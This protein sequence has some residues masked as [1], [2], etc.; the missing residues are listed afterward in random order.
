MQQV[1]GA[2]LSDALGPRFAYWDEWPMAASLL[3]PG[4]QW[5]PDK[6]ETMLK[7]R[8]GPKQVLVMCAAGWLG[9]GPQRPDATRCRLHCG[10]RWR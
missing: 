1:Y 4:L 10:D 8:A 3:R 5:A 2:L 6:A 9:S 7:V